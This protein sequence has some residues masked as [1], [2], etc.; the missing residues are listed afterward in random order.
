M[1]QVLINMVVGGIM[2]YASAQLM[3][4]GFLTLGVL[5]LIS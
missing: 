2:G 1:R 5:L 3:Q 4:G